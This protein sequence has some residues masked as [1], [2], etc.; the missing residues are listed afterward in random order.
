MRF[1]LQWFCL[2]DVESHMDSSPAL[3][4][5]GRKCKKH[6]QP[7]CFIPPDVYCE[8]QPGYTLPFKQMLQLPFIFIFIYYTMQTCRFGWQ[9]CTHTVT[10]WETK[11]NILEHHK[12]TPSLKPHWASQTSEKDKDDC[13]QLDTC[14]SQVC[15]RCVTGTETI[16]K[17][18]SVLQSATKLHI[19]CPKLH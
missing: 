2:G 15:S 3:R 5:E 1:Q 13:W 4:A 19:L 9:W 18:P 12:W 14:I 8:N 11:H 10:T 6:V 16:V 17:R 7:C